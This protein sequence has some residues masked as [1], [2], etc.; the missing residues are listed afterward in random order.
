MFVYEV[1]SDCYGELSSELFPLEASQRV[2]LA[3]SSDEDV[4][5]VLTVKEDNKV[6]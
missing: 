2:S 1:S 5:L 6:M 3:V 4:K